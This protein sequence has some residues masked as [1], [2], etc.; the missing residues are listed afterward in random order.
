[1]FLWLGFLG[2]DRLYPL[3]DP[4][5]IESVIV[6]AKDDTPLRAFAD[7]EGVWRYP[8]TLD[9]VSP[10]YLQAL[11]G[12]EDRWF[13]YHFGINP[14]ALLRAGWQWLKH[15]RIISGGSTLTMQVARILD[16][17][18]RS[19]PGKLQQMFRALQL[20]WHYSKD[21]ILTFYLNLAPFGGP[22]EGVQ[23]ASYAY[24][25]KPVNALSHA[26]AALLAV[27]PQAPSLLRPDRYPEKAQRYRDKLL[28]RMATLEVWDAKVVA[29]ARMENVVQSGFR[30]PMHAPLFTRRIKD[31][32]SYQGE[33]RVRTALNA[34]FQWMAE[35]IVR[36]RLGMLPDNASAAVLVM[37]NESGLV[38]AYVGSADFFS[39]QRAGQVDMVQALRS[40]GST[41][42]PF[43]YGLAMD[44]GLVHSASL[45]SDVPL[46]VSGYAPKNFRGDYQGAVTVT[47]ALQESLNIPAVDILQRL[48]PAVFDARLQHAG[49][50]L[51]YP[52]YE[53]PNLSLIL[54]GAGTRLENLV[55][56][57]S[58][59]AREGITVRPRYS[60]R[61]AVEERRILSPEASWVIH[62]ILSDVEPPNGF[63]SRAIQ[64]AWKTGT[65]YGF[66]DAWSVGVNERY[67]V[68]V[69]TGRPDGTPL[70]GQ[71][72]ARASGPLLFEIFQALPKPRRAIKRPSGVSQ[73]KICWPLGG[74]VADT[75]AEQ[76]HQ[77]HSA[78]LIHST[79]PPT[80]PSHHDFSWSAG[81]KSFWVNPETG[82]R[83]NASCNSERRVQHSKAQ[84][85]FE[86]LPWL[87]ADLRQRMR[88]PDFD[89]SCP[90]S[91]RVVKQALSIESL[92][93]RSIIRL[94]RSA[95]RA[96][97]EPGG[98]ELL[99]SAVGGYGDYR[100]LLDGYP[101]GLDNGGE[102]LRYAL[103]EPGDH[104]LMVIDEADNVD[105]VSIR[106]I[107]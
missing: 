3:P 14:V 28:S 46:R 90:E 42:K 11:L 76:C 19:V 102:G 74:A 30:Q 63:S 103:T 75:P 9:E 15:G 36:S 12:Y 80:L 92:V 44:K 57:F 70:P 106:L 23:T 98:V 78:W 77:L 107:R 93:D 47:Q 31:D 1:M 5:R 69:W 37:E 34:D 58:A 51:H 105:K 83:V 96:G 4:R 56:G 62:D 35:G 66:R 68:G 2:L 99:L 59:L 26:E 95:G 81:L 21:E 85:P 53:T 61:E 54:G 40:P 104:E 87:S 38:R 97:A 52:D 29:D 67:T 91:L 41:L 22:I 65:S 88:L 79:I 10:L 64:L 48:T 55:R 86:L 45:L 33:S 17:H 27:L 101:I 84:W 16:R 39:Q 71:Y 100:W 60:E 18:S 24:L 25:H 8:V 32:P 89:G 49:I 94:P 7:P 43:L 6:L 13:Y 82:L 20:E 50:H 73:K 72:G